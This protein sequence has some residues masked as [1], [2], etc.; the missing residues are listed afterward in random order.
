MPQCGVRQPPLPGKLSGSPGYRRCTA[1][2]FTGPMKTWMRNY[3]P[4]QFVALFLLFLWVLPGLVF[5]AW[6]WGRYK[7]P[8]CGKVGENAP[9]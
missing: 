9:A 7:C 2:G 3:N 4:P 1:C 5:I 8:N 6:H